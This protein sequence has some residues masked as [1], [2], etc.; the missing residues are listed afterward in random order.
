MK[1]AVDGVKKEM[2]KFLMCGERQIKLSE[3][4]GGRT[5]TIGR[6]FLTKSYRLTGYND[7]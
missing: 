5:V 4:I 7:C 3:L 2:K 6:T 1:G